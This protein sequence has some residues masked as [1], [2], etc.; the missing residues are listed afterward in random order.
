M[1]KSDGVEESSRQRGGGGGTVTGS[2]VVSSTLDRRQHHHHQQRTTNH[3]Q[4]QRDQ[5]QRCD[6]ITLATGHHRHQSRVDA[7]SQ[8][9]YTEL[10]RIKH[11]EFSPQSGL[12]V[13]LSL[14]L[15]FS[16]VY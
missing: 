3:H 16:L 10:M 5:H 15:C 2:S 1:Q 7:N 6:S 9:F 11:E 4:Q 8:G 12:S 14:Y 13:C